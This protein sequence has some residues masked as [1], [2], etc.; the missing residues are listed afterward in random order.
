MAKK[1]TKPA[2]VV[3]AARAEL[4]TNQD[5]RDLARYTIDHA[6]DS[7]FN[8]L[9]RKDSHLQGTMYDRRPYDWYGNRILKDKSGATV[10]MNAM[11]PYGRT[12]EE[13]IPVSMRQPDTK[14]PL[15]R[16]IVNRFAAML[17][18]AR[19]FPHFKI[20]KDVKTERWLNGVCQQVQ[21]RTHMYSAAVLGGAIGSVLVMFR[22]V[23]GRFQLDT[24]NTKWVTP[25][26]DDFNQGEMSAFSICYPIK[27]Q[28][29]D[30]KSKR[31]VTKVFLYRRV[32]SANFDIVFKLQEA[33]VCIH[34]QGISVKPQDAEN[35]P[36][37]DPDHTHYHGLGFVPAQFIQHT[38]RA[39]EVDGDSGFEG[40]MDLIDRVNENLS[41][42]HHALQANLD[43]TLVISI[44]PEDY[45]KL[46]SMGGI[47]S[48]GADGS[49]IAVGEKG[50]AKYIQIDVENLVKA[51][52]IINALIGFALA[53]C[54]C[55]IADPHKLT[56]AAQSA[57]A[58]QLLYSPMLAKTDVLRTQYGEHALRKLAAKMLRAYEIIT[59]TVDSG[60]GL[61]RQKFDKVEVVNPESEKVEEVTPMPG[62]GYDD[63]M[64]VWGDYFPPTTADIFQ[65]AEAAVMA[66]G[67]KAAT[68]QAQ[69]ARMLAAYMNDTN[70]D[71]TIALLEQQE[72]AQ[73]VREEKLIAV[74]AEAKSRATPAPKPKTGK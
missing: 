52:D 58:I 18:S 22:V 40:A 13:A 66:T 19:T 51:M 35:L 57:A 48:T 65:A 28:V 29:Y 67:G 27:K 60:A 31:Y 69:A 50:D 9:D 14:Y 7:R 41:A 49:G 39:D 11:I 2:D 53:L 33:K 3:K 71:A 59:A 16:I 72:A 38:P 46:M 8:D 44:A 73:L 54:D 15:G 20:A 64:L 61:V 10:G 21:M 36:E 68:T 26:W 37:I 62:I 30:E 74:N 70:V 34:G 4:R 23:E 43:P 56:G 1:S 17:F 32:V 5:L 42:V 24:F 63:M 55:V 12:N 6:T 25:L 47:V 45:T